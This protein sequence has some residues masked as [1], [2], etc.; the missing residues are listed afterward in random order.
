MSNALLISIYIEARLIH[1]NK[2]KDELNALLT[3]IP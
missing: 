2:E 3:F 1:K